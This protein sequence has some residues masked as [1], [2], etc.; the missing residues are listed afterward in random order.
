MTIEISLTQLRYILAVAKSGH[1]SKAATDCL[2]SQPTLSTQIQKAEEQLGIIIFDRT[3]K[4]VTPTEKGQ[5]LIEQA[6]IIMNDYRDLI[7]ITTPSNHLSGHYRI[8]LIP[9][10]SPYLLPPFISTFSS[11]Y[12]HIQLSITTDK[13]ASLIEN[14]NAHELDG[15]ILAT[16]ID[17]PKLQEKFITEDPFY[18]FVSSKTGKTSTPVNVNDL[19][20]MPVWL[21]EDGHCFRDQILDICTLNLHA[22]VLPNVHFLGGSLETL[23]NLI[24]HTQGCTILPKMTLPFLS[25]EDLEN[26]I[27]EFEHPVPSR[28]IRFVSR[29]RTV[30]APIENAILSTCQALFS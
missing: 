25:Q 1:F 26:H 12:P 14:L 17:S 16:P 3:T 27:L 28:N 24:K 10:I 23:T 15:C 11:Q 13:T 7:S 9:T 2:V 29:R 19:G 5:L 22:T 18:L 6:Q 20:K 4:P 21:L 30:K 8:G